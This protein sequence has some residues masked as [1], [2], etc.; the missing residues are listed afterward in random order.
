M[1]FPV[2]KAVS[3]WQISASSLQLFLLLPPALGREI[4]PSAQPQYHLPPPKAQAPSLLFFLIIVLEH[5]S[6][7][8]MDFSL[9]PHPPSTPLAPSLLT[10]HCSVT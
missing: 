10:R 1:F 2:L 7:L 9:E 8:L 4:A 3:K 5:L 6:V